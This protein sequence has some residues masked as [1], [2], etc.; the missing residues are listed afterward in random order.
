MDENKFIIDTGF[1][2]SYQLGIRYI[3][4]TFAI[5]SLKCIYEEDLSLVILIIVLEIPSISKTR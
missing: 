5:Y 4:Y 1:E 2:I 3:Q